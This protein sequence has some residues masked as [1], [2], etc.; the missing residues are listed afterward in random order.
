MR[1][2]SGGATATG[3]GGPDARRPWGR[4]GGAGA[5]TDDDPRMRILLERAVPGWLLRLALALAVLASAASVAQDTSHL[6]A[7]VL[8]GAV[9]AWRPHPLL[10]GAVVALVA[11]V[12]LTAP[13]GPAWQLPALVLA[14][15]LA[16]RLGVLADAV[17]WTAHVEAGV[18]ADAARPFV[19][20]QAL[21]QA[22]ALAATLLAGAAPVPWLAVGA[23]AALAVL[24]WATLVPMLAHT[25]RRR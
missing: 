20:I 24:A 11:L 7:G 21:A 16:W 10:L 19:A 8:A 22:L 5:H 3:E 25:H 12:L 15:H 1:A 6:V 18:L 17:P 13:G 14:T 9:L 23:A 4:R 2:R